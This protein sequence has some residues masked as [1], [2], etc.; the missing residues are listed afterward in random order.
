MIAVLRSRLRSILSINIQPDGGCIVIIRSALI[1]G[2][3]E[4]RQGRGETVNEKRRQ[5]R[6]EKGEVEGEEKAR[7][8]G[9]GEGEGEGNLFLHTSLLPPVPLF[10][11]ESN[12]TSKTGHQC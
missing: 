5:G 1:G 6:R 12:R 3:E 9:E 7:V 4:R 10:L 8:K 2:T 11:E